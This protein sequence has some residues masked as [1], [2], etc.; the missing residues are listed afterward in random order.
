MKGI[1][2]DTPIEEH[3]GIHVKREDLCAP[4]EA[5]PF[6]KIR[7]LVKHL[8][9]LK[10]DGRKGVAYVETSISMAGW[11]VA[12]ACYLLDLECLI[13]NPVY[14]DPPPLLLFH[15]EQ[16]ERWGAELRDLPAGGAKVNYYAA[17]KQIPRGYHLLP[18]GLPLPET[19][20]ETC[21]I[22]SPIVEPYPSIVACVG[23]GTIAAGIFQATK[24]GQTLYGVMCRTGDVKRKAK[25]VM[26]ASLMPFTKG[27]LKMIDKGWEYAE[28][29]KVEVP[30]PCHP[31]YDAKAWEW[32]M[33]N[34]GELE[35]P[36]LFWNIG[37]TGEFDE[38]E[39]YH[40][41]VRNNPEEGQSNRTGRKAP[42]T[43]QAEG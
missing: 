17:R 7:G 21:S 33:E 28:P 15:Q 19:V 14:K 30:F 36:I 24:R 31:Y 3:N 26:S 5:P 6:S 42:T 4:P 1:L 25:R 27:T 13:F 29:S 12:W 18:L 34:K 23:S 11:G 20:S 38:G 16:W 8:D 2:W 39:Q 10:R 41:R 32:L 35:P 22:A 43:P 37:S 40:G 9:H